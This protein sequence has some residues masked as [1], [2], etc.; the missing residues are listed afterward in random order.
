MIYLAAATWDESRNKYRAVLRLPFENATRV[1]CVYDPSASTPFRLIL[2]DPNGNILR[3][4][5]DEYKM[6]CARKG[7]GTWEYWK[8]RIAGAT[9][10]VSVLWSTVSVDPHER[11]LLSDLLH[12]T[13]PIS[14]TEGVLFLARVQPNDMPATTSAQWTAEQPTPAPTPAPKP[15]Q[16]APTPA[17][18]HDAKP[19]DIFMPTISDEELRLGGLSRSFVK[20]VWRIVQERGKV[21]FRDLITLLGLPAR[22]QRLKIALSFLLQEG[23]IYEHAD[24]HYSNKPSDQPAPDDFLMRVLNA[25]CDHPGINSKDLMRRTQITDPSFTRIVRYL[26]AQGLIRRKLVALPHP[27]NP[28]LSCIT[29]L[30]YP[31]E[32]PARNTIGGERHV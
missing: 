10:E 19:D 32:K 8:L 1:E 16:L 23:L 13:E 27:S 4:D 29:W 12:S 22:S 31:A 28:R 11:T 3:Y 5:L 9:M 17:K 25:I 18:R 30:H 6:A 26:A 24:D 2:E 7:C 15:F 14:L 21:S 20:A